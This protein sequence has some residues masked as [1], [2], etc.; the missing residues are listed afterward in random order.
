M[1]S[2]ATLGGALKHPFYVLL[3]IFPFPFHYH[4]LHFTTL[5]PTQK[6]HPQVR[7]KYHPTLARVSPFPF[8][9]SSRP[10]VADF[11]GP[12]LQVP[13]PVPLLSK[14]HVSS[15]IAGISQ[16]YLAIW[17]LILMHHGTSTAL[18]NT[19]VFHSGRRKRCMRY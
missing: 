10:A 18:I 13:F 19:L 16:K 3:H 14:V 2:T 17:I 1:K 9:F 5:I 8:C 15:I 6:F 7:P 11:R 12:F 4:Q